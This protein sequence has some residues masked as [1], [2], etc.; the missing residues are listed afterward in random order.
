LREILR[1]YPGKKRLRLRLDLTTG[2]QVWIDSGWTG[3]EL[4]PEMRERVDGL[5]G[6]GNLR[7]QSTPHRPTNQPTGGR[8]RTPIR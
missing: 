7:L 3:V 8:R 1:G 6:P 5:L 2:G 4:H